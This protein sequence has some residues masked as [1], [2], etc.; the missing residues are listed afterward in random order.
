MKGI[1]LIAA[2]FVS[3]LAPAVS[4]A[5]ITDA[6]NTCQRNCTLNGLTCV[7]R[8]LANSSSEPKATT[9]KQDEWLWGANPNANNQAK[10][11]PANNSRARNF[12]EIAQRPYNSDY[13]SRRQGK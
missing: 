3:F 4:H 10:N 13:V 5:Q 6:Y 8:C 11:R 2:L 12:P 7:L 9:N 1:L